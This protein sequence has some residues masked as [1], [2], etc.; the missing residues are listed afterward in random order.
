MVAALLLAGALVPL[1]LLVQLA[2]EL[3]QLAAELEQLAAE[4]G[5]LA[6]GIS[7][8]YDDRVADRRGRRALDGQRDHL[9]TPS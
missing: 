4:L 3:E 6:A 1:G 7:L 9:G 5:Q 2:A 8:R